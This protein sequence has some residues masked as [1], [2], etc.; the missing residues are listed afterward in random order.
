M[1]SRWGAGPFILMY[2]S[3]AEDGD[4]IFTVS[5]N[6]FQDQISWLIEQ[7]FEPV[8]LAAIVD[9][10][11][12]CDYQAL[13]HKVAFTFDDGCS[14]FLTS[15]LPIL[16]RHK[17]P[18][19]VFI[20][21]DM[22]GEKASWSEK[23]KNIQLMDEDELRYIRAQ[24]ITLGSHTLTHVN[25][26]NLNPEE[27][28]R[29]LKKSRTKLKDLGESFYA[30]SYPWGQWSDSI[31]EAVQNSGYEC[32]VGVGGKMRP[33]RVDI[34]HLPRITMRADINLKSFQALFNSLIIKRAKQLVQYL[35]K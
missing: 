17:A 22:L 3:I 32:A 21:T 13:K 12:N 5:A 27:L 20:V 24:G 1:I 28:D 8:P 19:T 30:F 15:A 10:I 4:D 35:E 25:L 29:Q 18:A 34:Y 23:S 6:K 2:H 9:S 26:K 11:K 7:G 14:D 33:N 16:I 31:L